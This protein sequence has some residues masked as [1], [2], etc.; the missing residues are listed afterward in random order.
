[1]Q[2]ITLFIT[3]SPFSTN[4][5]WEA[6]AFI[7]EQHKDTPIKQVF[8]YA[9]ATLVCNASQKAPQGQL[10][11]LEEWI[12]LSH[13][14]NIPLK[15]CIANSVRRGILDE[16]EAQRYD[17]AATCAPESQLVGLGEMAEAYLNQHQVVQ[18]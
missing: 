11:T 14:L 6:Q 10:N 15:S 9:D 3:S 17:L 2:S 7:R 8:F 5:H 12:K 1:M 16:T 4:K 13:D 18:F